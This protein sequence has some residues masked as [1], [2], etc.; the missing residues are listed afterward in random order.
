MATLHGR[1]GPFLLKY[2]LR[3]KRRAGKQLNLFAPDLI[4]EKAKQAQREVL[5]SKTCHGSP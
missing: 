2:F 4:N 1:E 3:S 5:L